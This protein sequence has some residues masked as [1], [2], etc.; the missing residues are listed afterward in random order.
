MSMRTADPTVYAPQTQATGNERIADSDPNS[1]S[2]S[3]SVID[4]FSNFDGTFRANRDLRIEG[5]VKGTID[6]QGTLHI[7]QGA[8]VT[9]KVE[10]EHISVAGDL[11]GDIR[12][13]GRLQI[14]PSGRVRGKVA[15][16][17][18]VI[19]EGAFY[20][21]QLEMVTADQRQAV[22]GRS[23]TALNPVGNSPVPITSQAAG[24]ADR[25]SATSAAGPQVSPAAAPPAANTFIRRFGGPETP[26]DGQHDDEENSDQPRPRDA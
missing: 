14:M 5:E 21:G 16:E 6:C 7:A 2:D 4:R 24:R 13:R 23:R 8:N 22:S 15:T 11:N 19:N 20:E 12:C 1:L 9:A 17:T 18:L 26:F 25:G 10:A 3:F